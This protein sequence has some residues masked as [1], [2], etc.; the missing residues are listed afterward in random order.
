MTAG[1][2]LFGIGIGPGDP[3]LITLKALRLLKAA[4]IVAYP[5]PEAGESL[6]RA[7]AAPY[8][9]PTQEEFAIRVPMSADRAAAEPAYDRAADVLGRRLAAGR[10]VAVLCEGDPFFY[11]SFMYLFARLAKRFPV[12]V[13]PGVSSLAACAGALAMPLAARNDVISIVPAPLPPEAIID[14]LRSSDATAVIKVGR[15]FTKVRGILIDLGLLAQ[16]R[17]IEHASMASQRIVS[18][19]DVDPANVPYFSMILVHRRGEAWL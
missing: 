16:A 15:H 6:A 3:E 5:A 11:G 10:D 8:L 14:R 1:G 17:Y 2:R 13:V 4:A 9:S 19:D 12:D 7:I 18:L